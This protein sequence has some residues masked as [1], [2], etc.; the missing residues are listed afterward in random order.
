ANASARGALTEAR[1]ILN[2]PDGNVERAAA[3]ARA[4]LDRAGPEAPLAGEAHF[5]IGSALM[6]SARKSTGKQADRTWRQVREHLEEAKQLGVPP[7]D[8][9][10]LHFR[11]GLCGLQTGMELRRAAELLSGSVEESDDKVEGYQALAHT[12][13]SLSPPDLSAALRANEELR[14]LPLL[15]ED[16]LGPA[17]LQAGEILLR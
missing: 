1:R 14:Q 4:Y 10:M 15:G 7:D 6:R 3:L 9:P 5:L 13:L 2:R 12:Y 8:G 11:L 17:R 16:L